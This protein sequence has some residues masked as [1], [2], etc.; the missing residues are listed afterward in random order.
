MTS[1]S[2]ESPTWLGQVNIRQLVQSDLPALEWDGEY[3]HFR[4]LYREIY[5]SACQGRAVIWIAEASPGQVIGQMFVQLDSGRKELADGQTRAYIYG[6]RVKPAFRNAGLGGQLL[7]T[8]E[9]DLQV[10]QFQRVT[11]NVGRQNLAARRFYERYGYHIVAAEPGRW[12]YLD[13]LGQRHDVHEPAWR[14]EKELS[15]D[16]KVLLD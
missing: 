5:T 4:R 15:L 13:D 1:L 3:T 14:M 7:H 16:V 9:R 8:A 10:R 12:S 2:L 6:F 11:L